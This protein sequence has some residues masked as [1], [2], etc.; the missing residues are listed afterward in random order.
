V[1]GV[2]ACLRGAVTIAGNLSPDAESTPQVPGVEEGPPVCKAAEGTVRAEPSASDRIEEEGE[3][4]AYSSPFCFLQE[5]ED[6]QM[7]GEA[8]PIKTS[9]TGAEAMESNSSAKLV[10]AAKP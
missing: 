8:S 7:P 2:L 4:H 3:P 5:L 9:T 10:P 1:S 6:G